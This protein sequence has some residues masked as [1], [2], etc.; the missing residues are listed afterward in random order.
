MEELGLILSEELRKQGI[1]KVTDIDPN[2]PLADKV[3]HTQVYKIFEKVFEKISAIEGKLF[4]FSFKARDGSHVF[5]VLKSAAEEL[6]LK[7]NIYR[8]K[9][10]DVYA[11]VMSEIDLY[12]QRVER[13]P[14]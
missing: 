6:G 12:R 9:L 3:H 11:Q 14:S 8:G 7:K 2:S 10:W 4:T 5:T 1:V 13:N